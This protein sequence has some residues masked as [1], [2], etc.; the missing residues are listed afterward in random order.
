MGKDT[1]YSSN[2]KKKLIF[3]IVLLVLSVFSANAQA[4]LPMDMIEQLMFT[5]FDVPREDFHRVFQVF[6]QEEYFGRRSLYQAEL[7]DFAASFTYYILFNDSFANSESSDRPPSDFPATHRLTENLRLR[8]KQSTSA[9]IIT[10]LNAG[11]WIQVLE[12]GDYVTI[13]SISAPWVRIKTSAGQSGWL[14]SGYLEAV[15][16]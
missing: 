8:T 14:F 5:Q 10:T 12:Y 13:D 7:Q 6:V 11:T 1:M 9:D 16:R 2:N 4:Q 3:L 15:S